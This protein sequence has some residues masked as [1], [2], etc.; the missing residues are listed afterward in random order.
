M[1]HLRNNRFAPRPN[2]EHPG[3]T[4]VYLAPHGRLARLR[5]ATHAS[6]PGVCRRHPGICL[7]LAPPVTSLS[8]A[9]ARSEP[10][11]R[12]G[13]HARRH[14]GMTQAR[15]PAHRASC[16]ASR[17]HA[18]SAPRLAR[19][20][21]LRNCPPL[22]HLAVRKWAE[23]RHAERRRHPAGILQKET[24]GLGTAHASTPAVIAFRER[25]RT[26]QWTRSRRKRSAP[27]GGPGQ[28]WPD[29][30]RSAS[31]SSPTPHCR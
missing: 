22:G 19:H 28:P 1:P 9:A 6:G 5:A 11:K 2:I 27:G 3:A 8:H 15:V 21:A 30:P 13:P 7:V 20:K 14:E 23:C 31:R 12:G 26:R 16:W 10:R 18:A 25:I 24:N 4:E 29:M 17:S